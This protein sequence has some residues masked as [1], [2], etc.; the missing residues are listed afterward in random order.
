[1]PELPICTDGFSPLLLCRPKGYLT[2]KIMENPKKKNFVAGLGSYYETVRAKRNVY[3][4]VAEFVTHIR[5]GRWKLPVEKYRR[6]KAEGKTGEAEQVKKQMPALVVAGVCEG[7]HCKDNFRSFSGCLMLDIDHFQGDVRAVLEQLQTCPW[8]YAGWVSIS[9]EGIK[10]VV[11]VDANTPEEYEKLAYPIVANYISRLIDVPVDMQCKDLTRTCYAS[12][13]ADAF[14]KT[15]GCEVFPW[16]EMAEELASQGLNPDGTPKQPLAKE[17]PA[18]TTEKH[19]SGI[20][21]NFLHRFVE[22]N[23]YVPHYRHNFLLKLGRAA[24]RFGMN[25]DDLDELISLVVEE[26]EMPDCPAP[27]I[28]STIAD[29]FRYMQQPK[30]PGAKTVSPS[31]RYRDVPP[32]AFPDEEESAE[33]LQEKN[34]ETRRNAPYLPD[35]LFDSLPPFILRSLTG[36]QTK[37]QRDM[38]LLAILANLSGALPR[39]KMHYGNSVMYPHLYFAA[40]AS[41]G[42]GKG[43]VTQAARLLEGIDRHLQAEN[44]RTLQEYKEKLYAWEQERQQALKAKRKPDLKLCPEKPA[45]RVLLMQANISRSRFII[46]LYNNPDGVVLNVSELDMI[47]SSMKADYGKF[48][49]LM[50]AC[51]HNEPVG[52]DFKVDDHP[53]VVYSPKLA[54]C[55]AGTPD[56]IIRLIP[57]TENGMMSRMMIY[58]GEQRVEFLSQMPTDEMKQVRQKYKQLADDLLRHYRYLLAYPTEVFFSEEQWKLH[59][60]F[61]EALLLRVRVEGMEEPVG[62]VLR[63]AV[64][65]ARIAMIFTVLRKCEAEFSYRDITCT[66]EDF[67]NALAII[68]VVVQHSLMLTTSMHQDRVPQREARSYFRVVKVLLAMPAT[69]TYMELVRALVD[70]GMGESTAKRKIPKLVEMKL[71]RKDENRYRVVRKKWLRKQSR[72]GKHGL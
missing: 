46:N 18:A 25:E 9:G 63:H 64:M 27:E 19:P 23:P 21:R 31:H 5:N 53:Y 40:L 20:I 44:T 71:L 15:E 24:H 26:Y 50:R 60:S 41:S 29:A 65:A 30:K 61:F 36:T 13:D 45:Y 42:S 8:S 58:F 47:T 43:I 7:G 68:E 59:S 17:P 52:S 35:R 12:Y 1:M 62:I 14:C 28:R 6:L 4:T 49:E 3:M 38:L 34:L 56:Q 2:V 32:A 72:E 57:N 11:R 69:F 37:R 16:Q 66:D 39:V 51:F 55:A 70:A 22:N 33:T 67:Q 54:F 48:D 10:L